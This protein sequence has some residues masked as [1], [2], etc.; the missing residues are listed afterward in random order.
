MA[1]GSSY[2]PKNQ[3]NNSFHNGNDNDFFG[4]PMIP[5]VSNS[6]YNKQGSGS[7]NNSNNE[8]NG[9]NILQFNN[10]HNNS[11]KLNSTDS[12]HS[13]Y[14]NFINNVG[15]FNSMD[16]NESSKDNQYSMNYFNNERHRQQYSPSLS[17]ASFSSSTDSSF[18]LNNNINNTNDLENNFKQLNM[19][20]MNQQV[21]NNNNNNNNN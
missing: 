1:S 16:S 10:N 11:T 12:N 15:K 13:D 20:D 6:N 7:S 2:I 4:I 19:N 21:G 9:S 3:R 8:N 17:E 18:Y 14:T 5:Q